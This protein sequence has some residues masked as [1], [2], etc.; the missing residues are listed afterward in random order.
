MAK[1][2][3][4]LLVLLLITPKANAA[5]VEYDL[6]CAGSYAE[7]QIWTVDFDIGTAFYEI[8]NIYIDL[9][10]S[11]YASAYF[12]LPS[13]PIEACD[14][15]FRPQLYELSSSTSLGFAYVFGGQS[16]LPSPETFDLQLQFDVS[17]F[18]PLLDGIGTIKIGFHPTYPTEMVLSEKI[19]DASGQLDPAKLIFD[20]TIIPEPAT[21][22][23]LAFG[24]LMLRKKT[25]VLENPSAGNK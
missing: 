23:L 20:G 5:L 25:S 7:N 21:L 4:I 3:I 16:S 10:G 19:A 18:S 17:D 8:S 11:I 12:I 22:L 1:N 2:S 9:S 24:A 14:A 13:G 15:Y 6:N